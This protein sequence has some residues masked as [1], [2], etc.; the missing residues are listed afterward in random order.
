MERRAELN[1]W[2]ISV[3]VGVQVIFAPHGRYGL[4]VAVL[5]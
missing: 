1:L 2:D 5:W 4:S 3:R